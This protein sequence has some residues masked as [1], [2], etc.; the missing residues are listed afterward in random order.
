MN[1]ALIHAFGHEA[2]SAEPDLAVAALLIARV[3]YPA[4]DAARYLDQLDALGRDARRRLAAVRPPDDTPHDVDPDRCAKVLALN[5]FLFDELAF[6]G[7][8]D[9]YEDPRNSFLIGSVRGPC[10]RLPMTSPP[11][12]A[13][14]S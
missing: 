9:D 10:V 14:V 5:D 7:N 1:A 6:A 3:E 12:G 11:D 4:L 8:E 13:R 2:L